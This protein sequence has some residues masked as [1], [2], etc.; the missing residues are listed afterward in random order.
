M[1]SAS[2]VYCHCNFSSLPNKA[3]RVD[4][5]IELSSSGR[6]RPRNRFVVEADRD[7]WIV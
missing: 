4:R 7:G 2:V 1:D 3:I 5:T 6:R